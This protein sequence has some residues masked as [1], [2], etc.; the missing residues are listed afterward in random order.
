MD[1]QYKAFIS[2]KHGSILPFSAKLGG[3]LRTYATGLFSTPRRIFRDED[4]LVPSASLPD[5]IYRALENSSYLVL[6]ASP[7]AALSPWV[8]REVRFWCHELKRIDRLVI[9]LVGG[10]L[11]VN[12]SDASIDWLNTNAIPAMLSEYLTKVPLYIDLRGLRCAEDLDERN[13][14]FK[15]AVARLVACLEHRDVQE[16]IGYEIAQ[17]RRRV[18]VRNTAIGM[19]AGLTIIATITAYYANV[20]RL[21]Q[22][23]ATRISLANAIAAQVQPDLTRSQDERRALLA[24][25]AYLFASLS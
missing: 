4:H 25:Q 10:T 15:T 17:F 8:E 1:T 9:V 5:L 23:S 19:L 18:R 20:Q 14:V 3:S 13:P 2:Y 16:L 24:R 22:Q 11:E 6:L 12:G 21:E 7:E